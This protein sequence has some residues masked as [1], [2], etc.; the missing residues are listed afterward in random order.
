VG[1]RGVASRWS[2]LAGEGADLCSGLEAV[3]GGHDAGVERGG[4]G[5]VGGVGVGAVGGVRRRRGLGE[6]EGGRGGG[7]GRSRRRGKSE[8][9]A[10]RSVAWRWAAKSG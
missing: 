6:G 5:V 4:A 1:G 2:G 3:V 7:D 10:M 8:E 9:A